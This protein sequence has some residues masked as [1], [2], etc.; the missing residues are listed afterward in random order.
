MARPV[1]PLSEHQQ[2]IRLLAHVGFVPGKTMGDGQ[3]VVNFHFGTRGEWTDKQG[4]RW[5][6]G[7]PGMNP[8]HV[9]SRTIAKFLAYYYP[10]VL[11][12]VRDSI[13]REFNLEVQGR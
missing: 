2:R 10:R 8:M 3:T 13:I 7:V 12:G 6:K 9:P 4:K 1:K 11:P 5:A